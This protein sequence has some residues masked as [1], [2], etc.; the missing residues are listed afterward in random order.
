MTA[1]PLTRRLERPLH[2]EFIIIFI[3]ARTLR[4]YASSA[5]KGQ[6]NEFRRKLALA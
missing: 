3:T 2:I 6:S 1:G 5:T 4:L